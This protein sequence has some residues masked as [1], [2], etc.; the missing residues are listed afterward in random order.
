[1]TKN[2]RR[3][4][5]APAARVRTYGGWRFNGLTG[6]VRA[7]TALERRGIGRGL[8]EARAW[9]RVNF[10]GGKGAVASRPAERGDKA[11]QSSEPREECAVRS[12]G[13]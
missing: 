5:P 9:K 6:R 3:I 11:R 1:M 8:V 10:P 13:G 12:R 2:P 4:R 7:C